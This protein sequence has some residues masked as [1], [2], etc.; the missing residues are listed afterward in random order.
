V[1]AHLILHVCGYDAEHELRGNP[2]SRAW[3]AGKRAE[4]VCPTCWRAGRNATDAQN[5]ALANE[6]GWPTLDGSPKQVAWATT[7]R[8][9]LVDELPSRMVELARAGEHRGKDFPAQQEALVLAR[10]IC[11]EQ[12]SA[13]WWIRGRNQLGEAL[14]AVPGVLPRL[15]QAG[16][17]GATAK[18]LMLWAGATP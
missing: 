1:T 3:Q 15:K 14:L 13:A 9:D 12:T 18:A 11:L 7:L 4:G 2:H 10:D 6:R 17:A 16:D 8:G 5:V